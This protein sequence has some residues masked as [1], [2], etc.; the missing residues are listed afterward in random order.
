MP[1][2][3][4][5]HL[6]RIPGDF[7]NEPPS[8]HYAP[9]QK[10]LHWE[11]NDFYACNRHPTVTSHP[12]PTSDL[13][14]WWIPSH[15]IP[16]SDLNQWW[17]TAG[18]RLSRNDFVGDA[19]AYVDRHWYNPKTRAGILQDS[20]GFAWVLWPNNPAPNPTSPSTRFDDL[21]PTP[22][23]PAPPTPH[24]PTSHHS[25]PTHPTLSNPQPS[26]NPA[27]SSHSAVQFHR[28][29]WT[30]ATRIASSRPP[31]LDSR[32]FTW[33]TLA[34]RVISCRPELNPNLAS[35]ICRD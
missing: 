15:P 4:H 33:A 26:Q 22:S 20:V 8:S 34:E 5:P 35:N 31:I 17:I 24:H 27:K 9:A 13:N 30:C 32:C 18:V 1:P 6:A 3:C 11:F 10:S 21:H 2:S 7:T 12:I 29:R 23:H 16:T 14:Q 19:F 28:S 25:T